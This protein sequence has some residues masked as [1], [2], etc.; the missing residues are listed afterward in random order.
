M[1]EHLCVQISWYVHSYSTVHTR[2]F[3]IMIRC[4]VRDPFFFAGVAVVFVHLPI[5][6]FRSIAWFNV[7]Y[8]V[9]L[10]VLLVFL[11][12][13]ESGCHKFSKCNYKSCQGSRPGIV[14]V[15]VSYVRINT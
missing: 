14:Q 6:P 13:K 3:V 7:A 5:D 2:K 4:T 9:V 1:Y 12:R 15:F 11:F 10:L 8:G